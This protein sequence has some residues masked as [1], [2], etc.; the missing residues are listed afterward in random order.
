MLKDIVGNEE[1]VERLQLIANKGNMPHM[2]IS[3]RVLCFVNRV[4]RQEQDIIFSADGN[5]LTIAIFAYIL[6]NRDLPVSERRRVFCA[7]LMSCSVPPSRRVS[8][9]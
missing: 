8:S 6:Y 3:V 4:C 5:K 9:S 2:I 1:T 7:W